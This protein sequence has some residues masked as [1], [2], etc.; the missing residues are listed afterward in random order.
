MSEE[1]ARSEEAARAW[2]RNCGVEPDAE[3]REI[4]AM[5]DALG[6]LDDQIRQIR[7]RIAG[8]EA[9][10]HEADT[11][12]MFI[13]AAIG[14]GRL[15]EESGERPPQRKGELEAAREV[16]AAWC[17]EPERRGSGLG[18]GAYRADELRD[19]LGEA[20][21]LK[22]WQVQRVVDKITEA[23]DPSQPYHWMKLNLGDYGEPDARI[24][25]E[26]YVSDAAFLER[27]RETMIRDTVD[28]R[29]AEISLAMAIDLLMPCHWDFAGSVAT[30]LKAIGGDLHPTTPYTCCARN[31]RLSPLYNRLSDI[32]TA[33]SAFWRGEEAASKLD[34]EILESLGA[35]SP[36]KRW[37]AASL[38][39]TI[40]LQLE[41]PP[42]VWMD[43]G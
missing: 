9:C 29:P 27:T 16:L 20:T 15:G 42:D 22:T 28:G 37:L 7:E 43:L 13:V 40:R 25:G 3:M 5:E 6:P 21:P 41:A 31:L 24:A 35:I 12:A 39:K 38:D 2:W 23:L 1:E 8:F 36:E 10:Y 11:E 30:L 17:Q 26:H 19:F 33:L 18:V 32:S 34:R 14:V 4:D